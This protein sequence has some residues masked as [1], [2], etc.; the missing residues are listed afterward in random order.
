MKR[1]VRKEVIYVNGVEHSYMNFARL[2]YEKS[3]KKNTFDWYLTVNKKSLVIAWDYIKKAAET[4][5]TEHVAKES[6][7]SAGWWQTIK[8]LIMSCFKK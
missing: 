8:T 3:D 1:N 2:C 4:S 5:Y 7:I 6:H